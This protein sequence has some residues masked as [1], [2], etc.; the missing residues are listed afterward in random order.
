ML[1]E[2]I[3]KQF[4]RIFLITLVF[5]VLLYGIIGFQSIDELCGAFLFLLFIY[6]MFHSKNWEI[7]KFFLIVLGVFLFY[8]FY[9]IQIHSNSLRGIL[10][11]FIIQLK[12]YL[13]FFCTYQLAPIFSSK[14]KKILSDSS[15]V[16]W[17]IF[18][19]I[20]ILGIINPSTFKV[21]MAHAS[22]Y[23]AAITALAI[24]F[25]YSNDYS[26]R[27]I[28]IFIILLAAGIASGRSKF[29]GFFIM[30]SFLIMYFT[31]PDRIKL[32]VKN[33]ILFLAIITVMAVVARSKIELYF[34]Q[35]LSDNAEKDY[36]ARF[37]LYATSFQVFYDYFPLGS[38]FASFATFASGA[39]YSHIY[40]EYEIDGIWGI[41]KSYHSFISDTYYPSLAQFGIVGIVLFI[42]FWIYLMKKSLFYAN[43]TKDMKLT[44]ISILI[45][46]FFA[47]ENIAD[48]TFTSNRGLFFMMMLGLIYSDMKKAIQTNNMQ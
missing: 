7:N 46:V 38:G 15:V 47:I 36:V 42:L 20:G 11:D 17:V 1:Q 31:K 41:S 8:F 23:A 25:L 32:N 2:F 16:C 10:M 4:Y 45:I 3:N 43:A 29:Y 13:A 48:A 33:T 40:Q 5:G 9:S 6:H 19:P 30:A 44:V 26:K 24:V 37:V 18:L 35:G 39:Y 21:T 27:N 12:P 22:N 28:L 34:L 14:S